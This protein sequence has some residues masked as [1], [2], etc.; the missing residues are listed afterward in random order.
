VL[1][2]EKSD[3]TAVDSHIIQ[4]AIGTSAFQVSYFLD[5]KTHQTTQCTKKLK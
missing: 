3:S 2:E 5:H 4:K 1:Q